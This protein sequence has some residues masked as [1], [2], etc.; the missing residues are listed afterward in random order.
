MADQV[1]GL[2]ETVN[3]PQLSA[4]EEHELVKAM[5]A[6]DAAAR[7]RLVL[8]VTALV[9][10]ISHRFA[11]RYPTL[12]QEELFSQG[13]VIAI[14]FGVDRYGTGNG[15]R[16]GTWVGLV[17]R[18]KLTHLCTKELRPLPD[19]ELS[20]LDDVEPAPEVPALDELHML[21]KHAPLDEEQKAMVMMEAQGLPRKEMAKSL[22]LNS[23]QTLEARLRK[24]M[25]TL[26]EFARADI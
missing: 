16:L 20:S 24:V 21:L 17:V 9:M 1:M 5:R 6:G 14:R 19:V 15:L 10:S 12:E 2:P 4:E 13:I 23:R 22:G 18:R 25:G 11:A 8:S 3:A 7:E 26:E